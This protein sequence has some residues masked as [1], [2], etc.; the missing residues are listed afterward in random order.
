MKALIVVLL[1]LILAG[2]AVVVV[3][4][5]R[6]RPRPATVPPRAPADPFAADTGLTGDPRELRPGDVIEYLGRRWFVRGSVRLREGGFEW[7]EHFL[8]DGDSKRW[9]S[10]E[11]DPDLE[12]VLWEETELDATLDRREV[13]L[14]GVTYRRS[15]HGTA[16]YATQGTTGLGVSGHV[17]YV[18]YEAPG[19]R[20]L[21]FERYDGAPW[22]AGLGE[23]VPT[24]SMTIYPGSDR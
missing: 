24:G 16:T 23:R 4:L 6:R 13:T 21:S 2:I 12:L 18:D 19:G 20:Y 3:Q 9:V 8:D 17:E 5:A 11:E 7:Q 10:V 1:L 15:E 14:D 22:E